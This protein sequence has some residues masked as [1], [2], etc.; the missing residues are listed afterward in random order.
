MSLLKPAQKEETIEN[1]SIVAVTIHVK[2]AFRWRIIN[3]VI[4]NL[5]Y[6]LKFSD[7]IPQVSSS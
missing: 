5:D 6:P 2:I 4:W 1:D 7:Y 3:K